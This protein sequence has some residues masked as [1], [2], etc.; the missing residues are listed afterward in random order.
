MNSISKPSGEE[1]TASPKA[2]KKLTG[3]L[4]MG[5][6]KSANGAPNVTSFEDPLPSAEDSR[7]DEGTEISILATRKKLFG[8]KKNDISVQEAT[9]T[10]AKTAQSNKSS[11]TNLLSDSRQM[12]VVCRQFG[13]E[14]KE[15][16]AVE[17]E[18]GDAVPEHP[19]HVLIKVQASTVTLNDCLLR[20]GHCFDVVHPTTLPMTPGHDV[21]GKIAA[22]GSNVKDYKEGDRVAALIRTG[23]NAR[24]ASVPADSLV[25]VPHNVDSAE[26][27]CM[28][29]IFTAAYQSM[30]LVTTHGPMFSLMGKKVLVIGGMDGVGQAI[31]QM[32]NKAR[33]E[34]YATAPQRR[35]TYVKMVLGATP[36]PEESAAWLREIEGDMDVVFDGQTGDGMDA[37]SK[38]LKPDGELVCFGF[39][40][41]LKEEMGVFGAPLSAHINKWR[42]K[43]VCPKQVDIWESYQHDPD[44]FKKN[45][46]SLFQL[47][48]WNKIRPHIAKRVA[49]SEVAFAHTKLETGEVRGN[50]VCLP[51]KRVGSRHITSVDEEREE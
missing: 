12:K 50:V 15:V 33:A 51:W 48:K 37:A 22:V 27:A 47:L 39:S 32:C 9:V 8:R 13:T 21:V 45:L 18:E 11:L 38:A 16:M 49:L 4:R 1:E 46:T 14:A 2:T 36:L 28:V 5:R 25:R 35:H 23:G 7:N 3:I 19:D 30:K 34:I 44:Q 31:I 20:R 29:S 24:Y 42:S 40:S 26:A 10:S 43:L 41:M 6:H 17:Q